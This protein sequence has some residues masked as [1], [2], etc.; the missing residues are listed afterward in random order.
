MTINFQKI[1]HASIILQI[2]TGTGNMQLSLIMQLKKKR[3]YTYIFNGHALKFQLN[4]KVF[5]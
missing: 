1:F 4:L 2:Y 3:K 5:D